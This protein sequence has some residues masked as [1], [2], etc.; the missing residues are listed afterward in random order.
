MKLTIF[1]ATGG[2]GRLLLAQAIEAG[3]EVTAVARRPA[4]VAPSPARVVA[5]DLAT[6]DLEGLVPAV[7]GADAILSALGGP[8][9]QDTD[10]A[11]RGTE[12]I[13][14]A[15]RAT[16]VRRIAVV[17]AAPIGTVP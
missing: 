3:H 12:A 16:G 13:L 9:R 14:A 5:A 15:M 2:I 11:T 4:A 17:S 7:A 6:V 10:I 8:S 1:A